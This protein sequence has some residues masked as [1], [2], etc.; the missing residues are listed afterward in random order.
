MGD[1][2]KGRYTLQEASKMAA[3]DNAADTTRLL[4]RFKQSVLD[5]DLNVYPPGSNI[6]YQH[7]TD[8]GVN[9]GSGVNEESEPIL[10]TFPGGVTWVD[11][12]Y[13]AWLIP[14]SLEVYWDD[15][16]A[17]LAANEPRITWRFPEPTQPDAPAA[18]RG[19]EADNCSTDG[20]GIQTRADGEPWLTKGKNSREDV[21]AWV[22][23]QAKA[24]VKA[25]DT[26][27]L[28]AERIRREAD[29]WGYESER[30]KLT[31]ASI[32]KMLPS[33]ITGG[34]RGRPKK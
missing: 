2:I 26:T 34:R 8:D 13:A 11:R 16:N 22:K 18:R 17:W 14:D 4:Q 28:L 21:D 23:W 30:G 24:N 3:R 19:S 6:R 5:G 15:L 9:N 20:A 27:D 31:V 10:A 7:G 29:R 1:G 25:G 12:E 33:G 32:I